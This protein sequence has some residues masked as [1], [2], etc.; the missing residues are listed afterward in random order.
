MNASLP[1]YELRDLVATCTQFKSCDEDCVDDDDGMAWWIIL[2]IIL[3]IL[4]L[5]ALALFC[6]AL[7]CCRQNRAVSPAKDN[8]RNRRLREVSGYLT[9][10]I[11][12]RDMADLKLIIEIVE[13]EGFQRP[14]DGPY[15][16][17]CALFAELMARDAELKQREL[18]E[19]EKRAA[20]V[21]QELADAEAAVLNTRPPL[22][23]TN[24]SEEEEARL[25]KEALRARE[26]AH[27]RWR[28]QWPRLQIMRALNSVNQDAINKAVEAARLQREEDERRAKEAEM[29]KHCRALLQQGIATGD[30]GQLEEGIKPTQ[31]NLLQGHEE[32]AVLYQQAEDMLE[33]KRGERARLA[34]DEEKRRAKEAYRLSE[35]KREAEAKRLAAMSRLQEIRS[36]LKAGVSLRNI[37]MLQSAMKLVEDNS[38]LGDLPA[39]YKEAAEMLAR[40]EKMEVVKKKIQ[41]LDR[42]LIAELKSFSVPPIPVLRAMVGS[43]LL[44][45]ESVADLK[46][47]GNIVILLGK[48]GKKSVKRRVQELQLEDVSEEVAQKARREIM[49]L[50]SEEVYEANQAA[51][52]FFDWTEMICFEKKCLSESTRVTDL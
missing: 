42:P 37:P 27:S 25:V 12:A 5:V 50:T 20:R 19:E 3:V 8:E 49:G 4:I 30:I 46:E 44:M 39:E 29:V 52:L 31:V 10:A 11:S 40:L 15:R 1:D 47:W 48:T 26:L 38:L 22:E 35:E 17:A 21:Q 6:F 43:Y 13:R 24:K 14:L 32:L 7:F 33:Q 41:E 9:A 45:G 2:L 23:V 34:Q 16:Q 36:A 18:D 28:K 51:S